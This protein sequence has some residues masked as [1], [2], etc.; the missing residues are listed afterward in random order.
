MRRE[1]SDAVSWTRKAAQENPRHSSTFLNL[2]S[3]LAHYGQLEEARAVMK[4]FLELRPVS[5]VA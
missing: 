5:S 3:A 2:A 4:H 1:L